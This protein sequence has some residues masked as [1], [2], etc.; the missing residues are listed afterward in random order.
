M[1][2]P[3]P[4]RLAAAVAGEDDHALAH[5]ATCA[6]CGGSV[7]AQQ[8]LVGALR[9]M[10]IT[11]P[12]PARRD[13]LAAEVMARADRLVAPRRRWWAAPGAALAAAAAIIVVVVTRAPAAEPTVEL[14]DLPVVEPASEPRHAMT[15]QLA[16][17]PHVAQ[18]A[19][20]PRQMKLSDGELTV[21][22]AG[23]GPITVITGDT[24]ILVRSRAR[25]V[26]RGGVIVQAQVFAGTAEIERAGRTQVIQAGDVWTAPGG[27]DSLAAFRAG[28]EALRAKSYAEAVAAFDRATDEIVAEDAAFWSAIASERAGNLAEAARRLQSFLEKFSSSPR[29]DAARSALDRVTRAPAP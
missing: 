22:A 29:V 15:A 24:R 8:E 18:P 12:T 10:S 19:A 5:A 17:V 11:P 13:E 25:L 26:A 3:A 14:G 4:E 9:G 21:D 6:A 27:D 28:W 7:L 2:C 23:G 20:T 1:T 16:P